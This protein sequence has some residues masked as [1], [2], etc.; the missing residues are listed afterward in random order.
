MQAALAGK[1][2]CGRST[3]MRALSG[4]PDTDVTRPLTVPVPDARLDRLWEIHRV[5]RKVSASVVFTDVPSPV[6]SPK[7]MGILRC[8]S[9]VCTVLDNYALGDIE[10]D[11][12]EAESE[13][14]LA[15]MAVLDGRLDRLR[16]EGSGSGREAA[17]LERVM[18][19]AGKGLP[20]RT[21]DLS[22]GEREMLSCF[23]PVSLKPLVVVS[24]R[25]SE[26]VT[27]ESVLEPLLRERDARLMSVDAGF[28]LELL[29]LP[30]PER[31]ELLREEGY[32]SSG[33]DRLLGA[34]FEA[35]DLIV[36]FTVGEDEVRA[37]PLRRGST[38]LEAAGK[39]HSDMRRGFIRASVVDFDTYSALPDTAALRREGELRMEGKDYRVR[40]GDVVEVLFN[41]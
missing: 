33:L 4:H 35:L 38:A 40:D 31:L 18:E 2:G 21:M 14:I 11:L 20:L 37:W 7:G 17:L 13:M 34:V 39:I 23:S 25:M 10:G 24:N 3:L 16:K 15:D 32:Q 36:F 22:V 26:P 27:E 19:H 41:V 9:V 29:E 8:A 28:E 6:L 5:G 1:P 30:E 12:V